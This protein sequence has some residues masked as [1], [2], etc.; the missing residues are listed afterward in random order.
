MLLQGYP[1][2]EYIVLDGGSDDETV[3][4]LRR[5]APWLSFCRSRPD[6]GQVRALNEGFARATGHWRS[7]LNADDFYAPGALQRIGASPETEA[8]L[9]GRTSYVDAESRHIGEFPLGYRASRRSDPAWVD[10]VCATWSGTALPQQSS[11]WTASAH[12]AAGSLDESLEYVFEHEFWTRLAFAGLE[13]SLLD[14]DLTF[15]RRHPEQK[16]TGATRAASYREEATV[17]GR[18]HAHS[19]G[20]GRRALISYQRAC[21]RSAWAARCRGLAA[22]AAQRTA[23]RRARS[24]ALGCT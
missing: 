5:Y 15:Y 6:G 9:V 19:A 4:I 17:A 22:G 13:P 16:T 20:E 1:E 11:F 14:A 21:L 10:V 18:W 7:W 3:D 12:A 24:G 23:A 2:L 8:W